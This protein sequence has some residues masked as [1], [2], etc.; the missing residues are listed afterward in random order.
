[1]SLYRDISYDTTSEDAFELEHDIFTH[2]FVSPFLSHF[3]EHRRLGFVLGFSVIQYMGEL[4]DVSFCLTEIDYAVID[5]KQVARKARG[6]R[7]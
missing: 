5:I 7:F 4:Y 3:T 2:I 6:I 1:M